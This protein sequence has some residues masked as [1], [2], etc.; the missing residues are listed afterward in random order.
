[1]FWKQSPLFSPKEV[2]LSVSSLLLARRQFWISLLSLW[3][4]ALQNIFFYSCLPSWQCLCVHI[5]GVLAEWRE[6]QP[7]FLQGEALTRFI[8]VCFFCSFSICEVVGIALATLLGA[9]H[10]FVDVCFIIDFPGSSLVFSQHGHQPPYKGHRAS[11]AAVWLLCGLVFLAPVTG[12]SPCRQES[13]SESLQLEWR[14][15]LVLE[16]PYKAVRGWWAVRRLWQGPGVASLELLPWS[17]G[18]LESSWN[19]CPVTALYHF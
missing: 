14:R 7:D 18:T 9:R 5:A 19:T 2:I 4:C 1:M 11:V 6:L 10:C 8:L 16:F 3:Q 15:Q 13:G 17:N 12:P